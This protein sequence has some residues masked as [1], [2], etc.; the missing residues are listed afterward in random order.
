MNCSRAIN[1]LEKFHEEAKPIH[2]E[3][4]I[5][6]MIQRA[7]IVPLSLGTAPVRK[8]Q[9]LLDRAN[10]ALHSDCTVD[11]ALRYWAECVAL[12]RQLFLPPDVRLQAL[13]DLAL[14][15]E[16]SDADVAGLLDLVGTPTHLRRFLKKVTSPRWLYLL[17]GSDILSEDGEGLWWPACSAAVRLADPHRDEVLSWLTEMQGKHIGVLERVRPIAHAAYRLGGPALGLLL[18]L[19]RR[20]PDDDRIVWSGRDAALELD[21]SDPMVADLADVLLNETGW[22]RMII[23]ERLVAHLVAGVDEQNALRRIELLCFKLNKVSE[24]DLVLGH[25]RH[26]SSGLIADGHALFRDD[27]SSVLLGGLTKVVR[28]AWAW[29]PA[30]DLLDGTSGLPSL[31]VARLRAWI[32]AHAPDVD[33]NVLIA[34]LEQAIVSRRATGDDI[35][36]IDR[37][38]EACDR[39][40]LGN[41]VI[42]ALGDVPS[43]GEVSIALGSG[44]PLPERWARAH[45]WVALLPADLTEPWQVPDQV[46][47]ESYGTLRRDDLLRSEPVEGGFAE[48]PIGAEELGSMP[49][50]EAAEMIARWQPGPSDW[51]V[52]ALQLARTM[53]ALATEHPRGWFSEPVRI[54][55]K[56]HEP[57]YIS[58]YLQAAAELADDAAMPVAGL[59]NVI[60]LVWHEPWSPVPLG[61]RFNY[62]HNWRGAKRSA[63]SLIQAL[64]NADASFGDRSDEVWNIVDSSARDLSEPSLMSEGTDPLTRAINRSCTRAFE[65][66]ILFVAAEL[67]ASQPVRPAFEDLLSFGL[68]LRGRD[69]AEYRAVL[70]P[71]FAWLRHYLPEWTNTNLDRLF[72]SEAPDGLAQ[73]TIDIVIKWS[74][75]HSWLLEAYPEMIQDARDTPYRTGNASSSHRDAVEPRGLR[76]RPGRQLPRN[77]SR[78]RVRRW[79]TA[80]Q[81]S[82]RRRARPEL[83][84]RCC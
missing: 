33:P 5:T 51:N 80:K 49:P 61:K 68:Q 12:L 50:P 56:L 78:T 76:D 30:S 28:A 70:A 18:E 15:D 1:E 66:A 43:V 17:E 9:N 53:Q 58:H 48:S 64:A 4:L 62:D 11:D 57:L 79:S 36:L 59:L 13:D 24:H 47:T 44:L 69:G 67:R 8:Y 29:W 14:R 37:A 55:A 10:R 35:A 42:A 52:S 26:D 40:V 7:G 2:T 77:G 54:A 39:L 74:Q 60:Q 6:L 41:R 16:P 73:T 3:R 75:P 23:A 20:Y 27:R 65:T 63:V 81:P 46:L 31:V 38:V 45:T 25:F 84:R 83:C 71:R 21:A 34:E 82:R 22:D 32:L 72:G 19:V